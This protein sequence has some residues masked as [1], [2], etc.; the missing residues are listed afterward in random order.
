MKG[1]L[2]YLLFS[3]V[4]IVNSFAEAISLIPTEKDKFLSP[5]SAS[6]KREAPS[7]NEGYQDWGRILPDNKGGFAHV[8]LTFDPPDH[9]TEFGLSLYF[10]TY[11]DIL[12]KLDKDT[13]VTVVTFNE[14][15]KVLFES[16]LEKWGLGDRCIEVFTYPEEKA[17]NF[18]HLYN[19]A[20]D[21]MEVIQNR[22]GTVTLVSSA[23]DPMLSPYEMAHFL[24]T[25]Y[26]ELIKDV[27]VTDLYFQGGDIIVGREWVFIGYHTIEVNMRKFEVDE[28][29]II[30]KF[31]ELFGRPVKVIGDKDHLPILAHVDTYLTPLTSP[32]GDPV[33]VVADPS[34]AK[35]ELEKW[36]PLQRERYL[37]IIAQKIY[38]KEFSIDP[39]ATIDKVWEEIMSSFEQTY[40]K[41]LQG[42]LDYIAKKLQEEGFQVIR[43]PI[44][45]YDGYLTLYN[46][47]EIEDTT[48]KRVVYL[49]V[50]G[51]PLDSMAT[52]TYEGLGY[53]VIPINFVHAL[54][55]GG[56][57][58]C[59]LQVLQRY[60]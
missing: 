44:I 27:K 5:G 47:V 38:P 43:I 10:Q 17:K 11:E 45:P 8:F 4:L 37:R 7:F 32:G 46:N 21:F 12:R 34:L 57:V 3:I 40:G 60:F 31:E 24:K 29:E 19:W 59:R 2:R 54:N 48:S 16:L 41:S 14:E 58:Q 28:S 42:F 6:P 13:R 35:A 30:R 20:E 52:A 51:I 15:Q 26:P 56:G 50:Y 18:Y 22:D 1:M 36:S 23:S 33:I 39:M 25:L 9:E 49:P 55:C 53:K